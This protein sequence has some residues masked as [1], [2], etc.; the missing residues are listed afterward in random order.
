MI[1]NILFI[2]LFAIASLPGVPKSPI[3][4]G[5]MSSG[6][7]SRT[8]GELTQLKSWIDNKVELCM[9]DCAI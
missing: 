1:R 8:L 9:I 5:G 4:N 6:T 7:S 3:W 2:E